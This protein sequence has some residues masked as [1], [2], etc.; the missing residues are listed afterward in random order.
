LALALVRLGQYDKAIQEAEKAIEEI[1]VEKDAVV[2]SDL[3]ENLI[4][5][6]LLAGRYDAALDQL[7]TILSIPSYFSVELIKIDPIWDPLRDHPR[8]KKIIEYKIHDF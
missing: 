7:Q 6:Y 1:P 2:G 5:V 8:F 4:E 3:I